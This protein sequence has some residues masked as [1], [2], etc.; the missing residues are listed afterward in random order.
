MQVSR[1]SEE[2]VSLLD[3]QEDTG[4][5]RNYN[6]TTTNKS[7]YNWNVE[8]DVKGQV[9]TGPE[10]ENNRFSLSKLIKYTGPGNVFTIVFAIIFLT[11]FLCRL[12][13]V[14]IRN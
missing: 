12:A 2:N 7:D 4:Q 9:N 8:I 6:A 14:N 10:E 5:P 11:S 3:E 1:R 13:N